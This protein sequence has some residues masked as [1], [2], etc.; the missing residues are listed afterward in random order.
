MWGALASSLSSVNWGS[1][2]PALGGALLGMGSSTSGIKAQSKNIVK[3]IEAEGQNYVFESHIINQQR[4]E[5]YRELSDIM[6]SNGLAALQA[7]ASARAANAMRGV[8]GKSIDQ[9]SLNVAMQNNLVNAKSIA[10]W[11]NTDISLLRQ[12][13]TRRREFE[14][15][16][17]ALASGMEG[18]GSTFMKSIL[19][20]IEGFQTGVGLL[21][22]EGRLGLYNDISKGFGDI[23]KFLGL[24]GA[25]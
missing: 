10:E 3:Q 22:D 6:T 11:R 8:G 12:Q 16:T 5:V 13:A 23:G 7:E 17:T 24:G 19:G 9:A 21:S 18:S 25:K 20:G 15:R 4:Q 1:W 2:A 14:Q